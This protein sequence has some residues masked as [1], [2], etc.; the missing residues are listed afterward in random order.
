[1]MYRSIPSVKQPPC[2]RNLAGANHIKEIQEMCSF[3]D[4]TDEEPPP[5]NDS[6]VDPDLITATEF[7]TMGVYKHECAVCM[8]NE[9]DIV[10]SSCGHGCCP[11]CSNK[12]KRCHICRKKIKKKIKMY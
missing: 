9:I 5:V 6:S 3:S 2:Q 11:V 8:E 10:F 4:T 1:M 7:E 12:L